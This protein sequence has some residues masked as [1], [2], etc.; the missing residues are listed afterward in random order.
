MVFFQMLVHFYVKMIII[1]VIILRCTKVT[2]HFLNINLYVVYI[3]KNLVELCIKAG[4]QCS[5][6]TGS[7]YFVFENFVLL[8]EYYTKVVEKNKQGK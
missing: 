4:T 2:A 8:F 7:L 5:L 1:A 3:K 6:R